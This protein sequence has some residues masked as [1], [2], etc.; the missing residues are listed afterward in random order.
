M[1]DENGGRESRGMRRTLAIGDLFA[2]AESKSAVLATGEMIEEIAIRAP[3]SAASRAH[4]LNEAAYLDY[5]ES[6]TQAGGLTTWLIEEVDWSGRPCNTLD[7]LGTCNGGS[8]RENNTVYLPRWQAWMTLLDYVKGYPDG[9]VM[10]L[11]E[12]GAGQGLRQRTDRAERRPGRR[13]SG[14]RGRRH[15][16]SNLG[17]RRCRHPSLRDRRALRNADQRGRVGDRR[18]DRDVPLRRGP[19]RD[20]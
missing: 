14:W 15:R 18:P 8:N 17:R 13:R 19:R 11:G 20:R 12:V 4:G 10:T 7:R 16:R 2:A 6:K 3:L 9:V 1:D 5:L